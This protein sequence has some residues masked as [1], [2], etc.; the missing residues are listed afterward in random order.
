MTETKNETIKTTAPRGRKPAQPK[1][2]KELS[3]DE[4]MQALNS[5]EAQA[6]MQAMVA[7]AVAAQAQPAPQYIPIKEE[8]VTLL[9]MGN[10][11]EGS[12][13]YLGDKLGEIVGQGGMRDVPK[14]EFLQ[15]LSSNV[16][17]RLKDRRL[18]VLDGLTDDER[19]RYGVKYTDGEL[20][21]PEI[22]K[23]L[24]DMDETKVVSIFTNACYRHKQL[25][26]SL[27]AEA[28]NNHDNRINGPLV[29][30][31]NEAS[32]KVDENGMFT[33]IIKDMAKV[34]GEG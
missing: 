12:M 31:L 34:F 9:Y 1:E 32:K 26:A 15:S 19:E 11:A 8:M 18:I 4:I 3:H 22:Y 25:I 13:V 17:K 2:K 16:I 14:K 21:G 20:L 28:Y 33:A 23:K 6:L 27:Y 7:K 5:P 24:L 30:K 10:V 29:K